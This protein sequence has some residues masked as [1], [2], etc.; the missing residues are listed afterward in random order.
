VIERVD[1]VAHGRPAGEAL[2]AAVERVKRVAG[3]LGP[4]TVVVPSNLAGLAARRLLGSGQVG[5]GGVANVSFVTPFRL[6]E[7]LAAGR[8]GARRPLTNPVLAS[9]VRRSLADEPGPFAPVAGHLATER[10]VA[11]VYGQLSHVSTA[12]LAAL[13]GV[14]GQAADAVAQYRS[15]AALLQGFHNEDDVAAAAAERPDLATA[16]RPFGHLVWYLPEPM[17][18]ALARFLRALLPVVGSSVVVASTGAPDADAAVVATCERV[19]VRLPPAPQPVAPPVG[20]HIVSVTDP[21]EEVRAVIRQ[22]AA[23]A[24]GGVPLHRIGVFYPVADPY[25]RTVRQQFEAAEV[26]ANGPAQD[27]LADRVAGRT[28]LAAL[29]LPAQRW[30]RD[31]VL[32]VVSGAPVRHDG[33]LAPVG[34]WELLSR[35]A[36]VVADLGNWSAKL[37]ALA[38]ER[39][40]RAAVADP[41]GWPRPDILLGDA[42]DLDDL[43]AFVQACARRVGAVDRAGTW[44]ARAAAAR[45]LLDWL[46]GPEAIRARWPEEEQDAAVRVHDA[47]SRLAALDELEP[48]PSSEVFRRALAAEL[49]VRRGRHGRFGQGVVYGPL[50]AAVGQDLEAVFVLGLAE[51]SCPAPRHDDALLPESARTSTAGELATA[52]DRLA[53][54]HRWLLAALAAAP[55]DRRWLSFPRGDLRGGR[56]RL[57][58]RWLLDTAAALAGRPVYSTDFAGLGPPVVD[59]VASFSAGLLQAPTPASAAER[60]LSA[61]LAHARAGGDPMEHPATAPV[62]RGLEAAVSR[63]S[64]RFTV[65]DGNLAG[66]GLAGPSQGQVLSATRLERWASCGF[67]YYLSHVLGLDE[68]DE[69]EQVI[70]LSALDRGSLVH[71]VL[72]RFVAE[73]IE[74]GPPPPD[75]PWSERDRQRLH[76]LADEVFGRYE[77]AGLT[78]RPVRWRLQQSEVRG[79]LDAFVP[80]DD[81]F[82]S[83]NR[84]RPQRVELPFGSEGSEPV[85][86]VLGDGRAVR[87]RGNADRVDVT[88]TGRHLVSDYKT[89]KADK[90]KDLHTDPV[91]GGTTLQLGLYAEAA[92]QRLGAATASGHYW[93][94][95]DGSCRDRCGY[96]WTEDRRSRF[97]EVVTAI[98]DGIEDGVF[99]AD[100]GPWSGFR[101]THEHCAYCE[102][103]ALCPIDRG[104]QSS[105]KATDPALEVRRRLVPG[106]G[107]DAGQAP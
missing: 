58:S 76:E 44:A 48:G 40:R 3:P 102:F 28:L 79:L 54:Q 77:A 104:E 67:R 68:R 98:V 31:R 71:E 89:G 103:D 66:V 53:D 85:V 84:A 17:T 69:P 33:R 62:R 32:A 11:A 25:L 10:A 29:A 107:P 7:L 18:P 22:V 95:R 56:H 99:V 87:F 19:G 39:R 35:Q 24:E 14:G 51:G 92:K 94:L 105:A 59:V 52:A 61:A 6:A 45:A 2:A 90:Y 88:D 43:A 74:A 34:R 81:D 73:A 27:R 64:E 20:S 100:P 13:A 60:D 83:T 30:R 9:A 38:D 4:V 1:V 23:L 106:T 15:V 80:A 42:D 93:M 63:R 37:A 82:R 21:D 97:V 5:P 47:L 41:D 26:P 91:L 49:D 101:R 16:A 78:G 86:V 57:P 8:L 12:S 96:D 50:A 65:W 70:E 75:R 36:G 55:P 46:L 72:E